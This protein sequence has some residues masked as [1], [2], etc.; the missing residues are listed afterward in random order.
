MSGDKS[1]LFSYAT[2]AGSRAEGSPAGGEIGD[3]RLRGKASQLVGNFTIAR[4]LSWFL[5]ILLRVEIARKILLR[6]SCVHFH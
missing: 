4:E 5:G 2:S 3:I 1:G 6:V